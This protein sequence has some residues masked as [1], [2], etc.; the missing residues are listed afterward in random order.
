MRHFGNARPDAIVHLV[1]VNSPGI[2]ELLSDGGIGHI[3]IAG[4]HIRQHAH[5]TGTLNI[6][7]ST[8]GTDADGR[9]AE[10]AGQQ[11]Q[12]GKSFNHIHSLTKLG[13][14]HSPHHGGG[15]GRRERTHC[16][17]NVTGGNAG[18]V[19]N[20]LWGILFDRLPIGFKPFSKACDVVFVVQLLFQQHIAKSVD[21]RHVT[22]VFQ[23]QML[24]G[25]A[26]RFDAARIADD[27]FCTV[28]PGFQH[29]TGDD[30]VGVCA[31][32][33]KYQQTF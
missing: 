32:V 16:L 23:L 24:V 5:V 30:R 19:F 13:H 14:A 10:V 18:E 1:D 17:T 27:D 8:H 26:R 31:V 7:L 9:T 20:P 33:A 6:V 15:R 4:E 3:L 29:A 12:A 22:A 25:N 28:F 21:Q 11:R 2:G